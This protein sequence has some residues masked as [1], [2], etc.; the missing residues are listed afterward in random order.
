MCLYGVCFIAAT[1]LLVNCDAS[2]SKFYTEAAEHGETHALHY[3]AT[4]K[5]YDEADK[6]C[7]EHFTRGMLGLVRNAKSF[8]AAGSQL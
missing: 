5:T 6:Y 3:F 8:K 2:D 4:P 1:T 7:R